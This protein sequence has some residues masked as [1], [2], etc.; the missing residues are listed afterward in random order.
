VTG[1]ILAVGAIMILENILPAAAN[2]PAPDLTA[3]LITAGLGAMMIVYRLISKK[4][5]PPILLIV[6]AAAVGMAV[7][8]V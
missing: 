3:A 4:R 7:Y 2:K 5:F 8:G 6:I 1:I